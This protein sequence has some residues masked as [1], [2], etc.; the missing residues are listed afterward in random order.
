MP[1]L[2][3]DLNDELPESGDLYP[4]DWD[5]IL[6]YHGPA[7][8]LDY[9]MVWDNGSQGVQG[10]GADGLQGDGSDVQQ[11]DG[12]DASEHVEE[13]GG[14]GT[15][16]VQ[17]PEVDGLQGASTNRAG[18][19]DSSNKRRKFY[20]DEL[21]ISIYLELLAKTDPLKLRRGVTK[22]VAEKFGVPLR[23]VQY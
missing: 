6:E 7:H 3:I 16:G 20:S 18:A 13:Q 22:A 17:L 8:Q 11:G 19:S 2:E 4:I 21:K 5:E 23:I 9:D 15:E 14:A 1:G 12:G 10:D